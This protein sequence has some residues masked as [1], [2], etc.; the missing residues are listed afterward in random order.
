MDVEDVNSTTATGPYGLAEVANP[1]LVRSRTFVVLEDAA[2][3]TLLQGVRCSP[4]RVDL[5]S[6]PDCQADN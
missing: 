4:K 5:I 6:S 1:S 3:I 2:E